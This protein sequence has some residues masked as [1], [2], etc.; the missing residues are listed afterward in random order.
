[1]SINRTERLHV[2]R[3]TGS[4]DEPKTSE[5]LAVMCAGEEQGK[6]MKNLWL[7]AMIKRR[8]TF[9]P[10]C[11]CLAKLQREEIYV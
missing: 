3:E 6:S 9:P 5:L 2:K 7:D 8:R 1:M 10:P 11:S 4:G